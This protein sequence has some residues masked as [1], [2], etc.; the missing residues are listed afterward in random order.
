[1]NV[2]IRSDKAISS[3]INLNI[4]MNNRIF[5]QVLSCAYFCSFYLLKC[6]YPPK[7]MQIYIYTLFMFLCTVEMPVEYSM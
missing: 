2:N 6:T 5:A 4:I 7:L 1:M 3:E